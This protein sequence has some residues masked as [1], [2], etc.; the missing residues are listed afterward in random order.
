MAK[1]SA[2]FKVTIPEEWLEKTKEDIT[3]AVKASTIEDLVDKYDQLVGFASIFQEVAKEE[4]TNRAKVANN[5]TLLV[6]GKKIIYQERCTYDTDDEKIMK[7]LE[8]D[9]TDPL[10][11]FD[12][13]YAVVT[14]N[15]K[16]LKQLIDKGIV[17][18]TY[19]FSSTKAK[20]FIEKIDAKL[21]KFI[22]IAK[23]TGYVKGL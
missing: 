23:T 15:K 6:N 1:K 4:I 13:S 20:V 16:I 22:K 7:F 11:V 21:K 19:K 14:Q 9:A 5:Q 8:K 10:L 18:R 12:E 17:I 2:L 3:A